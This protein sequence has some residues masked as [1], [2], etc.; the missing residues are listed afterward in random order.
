[1]SSAAINTSTKPELAPHTAVV[2]TSNLRKSFGKI[3]ILHGID[4]QI[5]PGESRALVGRN[6]AGKSTLVGC[7]TGVLAPTSGTVSFQGQA[8]PNVNDRRAWQNHVACV[9]QRWT[10]IPQLTVA[11]NLF[12]NNYPRGTFGVV[13]W[14]TMRDRA[15]SILEQ[16]GLRLSPDKLASDVTVE[17]RQILEIARALA[18][19]SRFIILDEPTAE[20]ER[21][22]V[23]GLFDRINKLR[24][25]GVTFCYISHH[26]EEI[27]EICDSVTVLR[28]GKKVADCPLSELPRPALVEAM[29]GSAVVARSRHGS[30]ASINDVPD[31]G[32]EIK[33]LAVAGKFED[34]NLAVRQGECVGIAGLAASGKEELAEVLAGLIV[35]EAGT[36]K[37]NGK[38]LPLGNVRSMRDAGVGYVPRDR[39]VE[40]II[41]LLSI[42]ENITIGINNRLG[43]AGIVVPKRQEDEAAA[44]IRDLAIVTSGQHQPIGELSGGNQQ[45]GMMARA[46]IDRPK[47]LV[48]VSPTQ[49]VDIAS[50]E[51][52]F[53][54]IAKA[55]RAGLAVL[56]CSDELDEL[57]ICDRVEVIFHGAIS[58]SKERGWTDHEMVAAIEGLGGKK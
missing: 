47:L 12:L 38:N 36:V 51:A 57:S 40:G 21:R 24:N 18:Q 17:E 6:G 39:H 32:L 48:L 8:A 1:M 11:E 37:L 15:A 7:L 10:V 13:D 33:G 29:V 4:M 31:S 55:Q 49:G 43:P 20:L 56:L 35:P 30:G 22:E 25:D 3:E 2:A 44:Q 41:P 19:G 28:D 34:I 46:L 58:T 54:V 23:V 14:K 52:L 42:A 53:D 27:Y 9:Y 16:W 50:K 5:N 45:K 26:L